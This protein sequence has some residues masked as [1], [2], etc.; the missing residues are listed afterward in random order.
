MTCILLDATVAFA[1]ATAW[2]QPARKQRFGPPR[3]PS[4]A[5]P[6]AARGAAQPSH[7][8]SPKSKIK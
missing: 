8:P 7:K 2:R 6:Q 4:Q 5:L 1:T 3:P